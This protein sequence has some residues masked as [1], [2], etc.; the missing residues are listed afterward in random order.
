MVTPAIRSAAA[1]DAS[2]ASASR[3]IVPPESAASAAAS[4]ARCR[5]SATTAS[6]SR[7]ARC[8]SWTIRVISAVA[9]RERSAR[10]R[11]SVATTAN[12][13]PASPARAASMEAFI[14]S[15]WDCSANSR[16]A[17]RISAMRPL[18]ST[19]AATVPAIDSA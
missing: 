19:S 12:P 10:R 14:D 6:D 15:T 16:I 8:T 7:A 2:I 13:R 18:R 1:D 4:C 9:P 5:D 11:T 17:A 3:R